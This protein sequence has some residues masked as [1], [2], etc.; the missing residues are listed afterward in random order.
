MGPCKNYVTF[1]GVGYETLSP[2]NTKWRRG[3]LP[4]CHITFCSKFLS[5]IFAF[6]TVF[7]GFRTIFLKNDVAK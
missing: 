4:K 6:W 5:P 2:N 3:G 7:I 1:L